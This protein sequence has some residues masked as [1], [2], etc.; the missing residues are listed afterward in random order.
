MRTVGSVGRDVK[1]PDYFLREWRFCVAALGSARIFGLGGVDWTVRRI[2]FSGTGV[3]GT[4]ARVDLRVLAVR[5][6]ETCLTG[7]A[8]CPRCSA[9]LGISLDVVAGGWGA[10]NI[11]AKLPR[12]RDQK[13]P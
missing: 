9:I 11:I 3:C 2:G 1:T 5:G 10:H 13:F 4:I 12:V 6:A 7:R 8:L